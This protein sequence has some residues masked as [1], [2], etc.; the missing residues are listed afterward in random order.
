MV[1]EA[2]EL[3][4]E[5]VVA[6]RHRRKAVCAAPIGGRGLVDSSDGPDR[7]TAT[8]GTTAFVLSVTTPFTAPV[9]AV[10]VCAEA[11]R[12]H[13][14][15]QQCKGGA[16]ASSP[17][18]GKRGSVQKVDRHEDA[19]YYRPARRGCDEYDPPILATHEIPCRV[20]T[21]CRE[22]GPTWSPA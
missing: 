16:D 21:I 3:E 2:G 17:D 20:P 4:R 7:L 18:R 6:G 15:Q 9:V 11:G 14:R 1:A 19:Q 12:C 10:M 5:R 22:T 13:D 8:P